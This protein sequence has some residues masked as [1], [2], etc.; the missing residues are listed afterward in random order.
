MERREQKIDW[1]TILMYLAFVMFGWL[2]IYAASY[3]DSAMSMF[4]LD[5]NGGRQ[6]I[7]IIISGFIGVM[8]MSINPKLF[9]ISSYL[10]YGINI[11]LLI[12]VLFFG[13]KVNGARSWFDFGFFRLQPAEFAK[14]TTSMAL[15][16]YMS[17]V[18][19]NFRHLSSQLIVAGIICLP[20]TLTL[21]QPDAGTALVFA[22]MI[23]VLFREGLS[24]VYVALIFFLIIFSVLAIV[25][26]KV[27][28][29]I[30]II[31]LTF[32][33]CYFIFKLKH[34]LTHVVVGLS[35]VFVVNSVK[36][37]IENVMRPHQRERIFGLFNQDSNTREANWNT[38]QSKIAIGSGGFTGKGFLNGTQTKY[39]FVPQQTTDFI[40]CT[41]GEEYGWVG[42]VLVLI[43]FWF[44]LSQ[45][46][47]L[48]EDSKSMYARVFGYSVASIIFFH[49]AVNISMTIGLAPV[50]GI[51]L[52]F[53]SYGGSSLLAFTIMLFILLNLHSDRS[54]AYSS[55]R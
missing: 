18:N 38:T 26:N 35:L 21:L 31:A 52:P 41:I 20:V 24:Y 53:F 25:V 22:S 5:S 9:E 48:A 29:T 23:F 1:L 47:T 30:A 50:I 49:V 13:V 15:A 43:L 8:I 17:S 44:F 19:F 51:P 14:V 16:Q 4:D 3:Q 39:D 28:I 46:L 34:I 54:N 37:V 11:L 32:S 12:A 7:W 10:A 42:S 40:Y 33:S 45:L 6:F 2:N 36:Y 55:S 27:L